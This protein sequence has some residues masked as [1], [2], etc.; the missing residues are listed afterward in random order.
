MVE[1]A[2]G[3]ASTGVM[4][5]KTMPG[6]GKSG[7]SRIEGFDLVDLHGYLRLRFAGGRRF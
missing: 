6:S 3:S 5:L 1:N 2:I 4:S 7:T